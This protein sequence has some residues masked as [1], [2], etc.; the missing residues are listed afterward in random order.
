MVRPI[1]SAVRNV[2]A[3]AIAEN[4]ISFLWSLPTKILPIC[5]T[6]KPKKLI[7]PAIAVAILAKSTAIKEMTIR[8]RFTLTPSP[9]AVL[10]SK[11]SK[12]HSPAKRM[13]RI[14]P[15]IT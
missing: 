4:G 14:S 7:A 3:P 1:V 8:V 12:L 9:L 2:N 6:I 11:E 15:A 13:A 5:G 10:S